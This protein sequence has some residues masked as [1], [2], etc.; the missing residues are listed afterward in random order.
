[1]LAAV[2]TLA[3]IQRHTLA[4]ELEQES[5][6]LHRLASQRA[7]QHDA[8]LTALSAIAVAAEEKGHDLFLD[9]A[10][11]ISR[12]YPRIDEVQLVP[13]DPSGQTVGTE[14]LDPVAAELVRSAAKASDGRIA[15]LPH[16]RRTH[17]YIM[18][19]RSPNSDAARYGLMLGIDAEKLLGE[20]EPF[21]S[22]PGVV[23]S[24]SLPDGHPLIGQVG[25]PATVRFSKALGSAS[26]PLPFE[27][28]MKI[29]LADLYPPVQTG[30]VLIAVCVAYFAALLALR[31][32]ARTRAA[33]EQARLSALDSRLAHASRVNALGEMA[34]GLTHELTQ[35][36]TAILAQAQAGRRILGRG[37]ITA[38][39]PV[40]DDTVA[41]ARRASAILERFRNWSRPQ[42]APASAFDLRETLSNVR[43][44]LAPQAAAHGARLEFDI[45]R[46]PVSVIANPVEMEQVVFNL[47]RNAI[48]AAS[49]GDDAGHVAVTLRQDERQ[50]VLEVIDNG[51]GVSE[52]LRPRLFTPFM[53]TRVEGTG[54]GLALSQRLVERTGGEI[55]LIND[56]PGATF[57]VVLPRKESAKEVR[58]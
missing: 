58:Q 21:W 10:A 30:L 43:A 23:L 28:G 47:V 33:I 32:R 57:Q 27:T 36:L 40:L 45:P 20:A 8:H 22:R 56:G 48:E 31:Q 25:T 35:P 44:L 54:L 19:K 39:V 4:A 3:I 46:E 16:P 51:P 24:L 37:D 5:I 50:T 1:M 53:T 41:Q 13:L 55:A 6:I 42:T 2:G 34:S 7:D 26:Q 17:H 11:T 9:V 38:L 18:V 29:G 14:P 52:A 12:F 15:L 49:D